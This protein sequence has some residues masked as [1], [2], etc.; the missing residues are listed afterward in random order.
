MMLKSIVLG[1]TLSWAQLSYKQVRHY[2]CCEINVA[3]SK[4]PQDVCDC[5]LTDV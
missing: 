3:H 5:K 1:K 2:F 4:A